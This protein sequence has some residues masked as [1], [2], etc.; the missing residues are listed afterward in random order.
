[1]GVNLAVAVAAV[2]GLVSHQIFRKHE[3]TIRGFFAHVLLVNLVVAF[4]GRILS[5]GHQHAGPALYAWNLN[6]GAYLGSLVLVVYRL[7]FHPLQRY[8]GPWLCKITRFVASWHVI[9]QD[10]HRWMMKLHE[11]YGDVVR[12]SPNELSYINVSVVESIH[13]AKAGKLARG[14]FYAGDPNRPADS[15]LSTRDLVEH[16]WRRKGWER[17]FGTVQLREFEP[18]VVRH[19]DT[20]VRQFQAMAICD[21]TGSGSN[22]NS[23]SGLVDMTAWAEYFAYDVMSDLAFSEDFG[24]LEQGRPSRYIGSL[25]GATRVL[26]IAAQTPWIR[27]LMNY[28][29]L[30][31]PRAK[32]CGL[33][34][35]RISKETLDRRQAKAQILAK[36]E[37]KA[38][39]FA[40]ISAPGEGP[41]ALTQAELTADAALLIAAGAVSTALAIT[42]IFYYLCQDRGKY[43]RLQAEIDGCWDGKT[44]LEVSQLATHAAPYLEGCI[45][46]ALR[47]WPPAPNGMQ[48]RTPAEGIMIGDAFVP[49]ETQISVHTMAIQRDGRWFSRPDEFLPERWIES[50]RE[51]ALGGEGNSENKEENENENKKFNHHPRAF[52]PFTIGQFACLGKTLAY[53]ELKLF[54]AKV[55]RNFDF[56]FAPGFDAKAFER[57]V[58]FK[59]TLLIGPMML[60]L[61]ERS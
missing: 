16:R 17:G 18:R 59:G 38:D 4:G 52:I 24:M 30:L 60:K 1:M 53:Q 31:D 36:G 41:R 11:K 8:P 34:F 10:S 23:N 40:Y 51:G 13:G 2:A 50:E 33:D 27:P 37:A 61:K 56:E 20:L 12:V 28:I 54:M 55:V 19:L 6:L 43:E 25:H 7:F 15:M 58:K 39:M 48:R 35:A 3:P 45:N 26:T 47:L 44:A 32:Q 21:S 14:P 29:L 57:D 9:T 42:F 46:E 22:S 49:P 5:H